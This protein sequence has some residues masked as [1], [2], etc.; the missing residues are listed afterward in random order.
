MTEYN[1]V[2]LIISIVMIIFFVIAWLV[3]EEKR[4][5]NAVNK[6][7][8]ANPQLSN[9]MINKIIRVGMSE[10][11]VIDSWGQPSR[12]TFRQLQTKT[13]T[14]LYF[15]RGGSRVYLDDGYV[16]GWHTPK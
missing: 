15:G 4:R 13:K 1:F 5:N 3:T 2:M 10:E 9:D 7:A 6:Y 8:T 14:T 12:R 11:Q 16:T